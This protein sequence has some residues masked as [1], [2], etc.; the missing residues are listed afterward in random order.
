M[1]MIMESGPLAQ[2]HFIHLVAS[3][4]MNSNLGQPQEKRH[5]RTFE[6]CHVQ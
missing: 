5:D 4:R 1:D 6:M 3:E 2:N